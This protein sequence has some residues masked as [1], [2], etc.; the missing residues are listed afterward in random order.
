M[1]IFQALGLGSPLVVVESDYGVSV[2]NHGRLKDVAGSTVTDLRLPTPKTWRPR[3][4]CLT[5]R[6]MMPNFST[7]SLFRSKRRSNKWWQ[8]LGLVIWRSR[9]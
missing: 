6:A 3:I 1:A 2:V 9:S 5:F 4:L 7:G 8:V